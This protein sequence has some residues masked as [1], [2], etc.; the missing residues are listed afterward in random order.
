MPGRNPVDQC[1]ISPE[2]GAPVF[3][4][5]PNRSFES[6]CDLSLFEHDVVRRRIV[7]LALEHVLVVDLASTASVQGGGGGRQTVVD[8]AGPL[9][10]RTGTG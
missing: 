6:Y 7:G 10:L 2:K 4:Q 8:G 3:R 9:A 1:C 5:P